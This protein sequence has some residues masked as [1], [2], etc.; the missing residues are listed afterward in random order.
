MAVILFPYL[1]LTMVT[2]SANL[3]DD[4]ATDSPDYV[5]FLNSAGNPKEVTIGTYTVGSGQAPVA[6][7]KSYPDTPVGW[8]LFLGRAAA[9][10]S[11]I[12]EGWAQPVRFIMLGFAAPV[13]LFFTLQLAQALSFFIGNLF[14]RAT[15]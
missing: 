13:M 3:S 4:F 10:D 6:T 9:L 12:W 7:D 5:D 1:M 14:G 15:P 8:L 2:A 11:V